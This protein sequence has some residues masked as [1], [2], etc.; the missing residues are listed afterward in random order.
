MGSESGPP[1]DSTS[2]PKLEPS[3][4]AFAIT[5]GLMQQSTLPEFFAKAFAINPA[6]IGVVRIK[7]GMIIEVNDAWQSMFGYTREEALGRTSMELGLWRSTAERDRFVDILKKCGSF[8]NREETVLRRSGETFCVL[9]SAEFMKIAGEGYVLSTWLDIS[10]RKQAEEE[11]R[12]ITRRHHLATAS[13]KAGVWDWNPQTGEM[14]WNNR[15]FE[16]Y[17]L[18]PKEHEATVEVWEKAL[19]P[20]DVKRAVQAVQAA[21]KGERD[22]DT[23]FQIRRPDGSIAHIKANGLVLYDETGTPTRMIGLNT[24]ITERKEAEQAL[25]KSQKNL[26]EAQRQMHI[27]SFE[28]D[29]QSGRLEWSEE[30]FRICGLK[31]EDFHNTLQDFLDRVHPEDVQIVKKTRDDGCTQAGPLTVE[32]RILR[33][34]GDTRFIRMIFETSFH[35]GSPVRRIG[36]FQDITEAKT[37]EDERNRLES[38]LQQ[39]QKMESIGRLAGGVAHDFN[40]MLS[41]ILGHV[42]LALQN[43]DEGQ[44]LHSDLEE[45]RKAAQRSADLTRQLLAFARRQTIAPKTLDLNETIAGTIN[46]LRRLIGENITLDWIPGRD[47]WKIVIDPSQIDQ[48]LTNLCVNARDAIKDVGRITIQTSNVVYDGEDCFRR[49]NY[50][51]REYVLLSLHDDGHGMDTETMKH[52]FEPFFTTKGIGEGTGLGLAT[53]YGIVRQNNGLINVHSK[54]EQGTRFEIYFPRSD[55]QSCTVIPETEAVD[56][57]PPQ[58]TILAVEDEPSILRITTRMLE[59]QGYTVLAAGGPGEALRL[60]KEYPGEINILMTDVVMPEMNGRELA[61]TLLAIHPHLKCL[62][63]SGWTSD[64]IAQRENPEPGTYFLPK[65]FSTKD[66]AAILEKMNKEPIRRAAAL[67][68]P[69]ANR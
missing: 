30:M 54:P 20:E 61:R 63:V 43:V 47:L 11:L 5:D 32:F 19:H 3:S 4:K 17:G 24:D 21:L 46:M 37:A 50:V 33:P 13:A 66:L 12:E 40:N 55:H 9:C 29:F 38:Q 60:A 56:V 14:L 15:M 42:E 65:P 48:I 39:A 45:I 31:H 23:E 67:S 1:V 57:S 26:A 6:A 27:G 18:N 2:N 59:R 10:H 7:D 51:P 34:D 16:M 68:G 69:P 53:V 49:S 41:V 62:F 36:T 22:Y 35:A 25:K 64:A 52:I 28:Y 44:P 58:Q 8:R